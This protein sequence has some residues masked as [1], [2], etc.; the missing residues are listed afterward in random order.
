MTGKTPKTVMCR[1][2]RCADAETGSFF[3]EKDVL[4]LQRG[5]AQVKD[6]PNV[7]T[8]PQDTVSF[9]LSERERNQS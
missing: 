9:R 1:L 5:Q 2:R 8:Q 4:T 7:S 6:S 3:K